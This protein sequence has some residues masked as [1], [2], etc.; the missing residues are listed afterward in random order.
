MLSWVTIIFQIL[1]EVWKGIW[2]MDKPQV[3]EVKDEKPPDAVVPSD[4]DLL[5]ELRGVRSRPS[6]ED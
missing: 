2:G 1:F 3:Y 4:D 5:D 6:S